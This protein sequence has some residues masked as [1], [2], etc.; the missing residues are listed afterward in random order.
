M[1]IGN[2]S[3]ALVR[4][5]DGALYAVSTTGCEKL[6]WPTDADYAADRD[7]A[8][9]R[10]QSPDWASVRIFDPGDPASA[11]CVIDPGDNAPMGAGRYT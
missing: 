11:M 3:G 7:V 10:A 6:D 8:E 1:A 4:G 2:N 5:A 9:A